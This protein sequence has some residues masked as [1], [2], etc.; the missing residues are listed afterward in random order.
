LTN[1]ETAVQPEYLD[2]TKLT[3]EEYRT[4][5]EVLPILPK[6]T[7]LIISSDQIG[8]TNGE[9]RYMDI[10]TADRRQMI[11]VWNSNRE[12]PSSFRTQH[13]T[14]VKEFHWFFLKR[15]GDTHGNRPMQ[16]LVY[17]EENE[18]SN[19]PFEII[20]PPI[21]L[22]LAK[23]P[24]WNIN[25]IRD[26]FKQFSDIQQLYTCKDNSKGYTCHK[27]LIP[28]IYTNDMDTDTETA[29]TIIKKAVEYAHA[30]TYPNRQ[31]LAVAAIHRREFNKESNWL[32]YVLVA[33]HCM[34]KTAKRVHDIEH[35]ESTK[36]NPY[37]RKYNRD[38]PF[39][40]T[41]LYALKQLYTKNF[42]KEETA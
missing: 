16:K 7:Q 33:R 24:K 34:D 29:D 27:I 15:Y 35:F 6:K 3:K 23:N 4:I 2:K 12:F 37:P 26:K 30:K 11:E 13:Q 18:E 8:F 10:Y 22:S 9:I 40:V 41:F 19:S 28:S 5:V 1:N 39:Q 17:Q 31:T 36:T 38:Y 25:H 42:K 20:V 32:I 21:G 14:D